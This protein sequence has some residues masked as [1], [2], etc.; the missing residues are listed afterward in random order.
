MA[1][2]PILIRILRR[3]DIPFL[4]PYR[5]YLYRYT[6][7]FLTFLFYTSYHLSRKPISIVKGELHRN[8]SE[9]S[10]YNLHFGSQASAV[11]L[12]QLPHIDNGDSVRMGNDTWCDWKPFDQE[13]YANLFGALD[14]AFL[15]SYAL[16][17]FASGYIGERMPLRYFLGFGMIICGLCTT[18]FGM[19]YFWN[20]HNLGF[21][22]VAQILNGI[23]QTTGWPGVVSAVGKW[24]GKG[25][26][27][28]IMGVWN[29]HT[30]VGNILGSV[31][32]SKFVQ[33]AWGWSFV[34]PGIII[35]SMGI[36]CLLALVEE[37]K[38]VDC[39][40]PVHEIVNTSGY[41]R[42]A[43]SEQNPD[44]EEDVM[45]NGVVDSSA[46]HKIPLNDEDEN[47]NTRVK[48][49]SKP[50]GIL[51]ALSIPGVVEFSLSLFFAKLVS[52]TFLFWLPM[53]IKASSSMNAK[54]SGLMSTFFD[55][56]GIAGGIAAGLW[57]DFTGQRASTCGIMLI[58]GAG[59]MYL[60][61]AF[62]KVSTTWSIVLLLTT[63]A[64]V[65]GPYALITTAVSADLGTHSVLRG[66][67]KAIATVT[68][69]IDGTGSIGAAIGPLLTGLIAP[70]GKGWNN[71]FYMLIASNIAS[72]LLLL[73]II[74]KEMRLC[75][76]NRRSESRRIPS[77]AA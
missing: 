70:Q 71:V 28:F 36:L 50:I 16:S 46:S 68:A 14:Y 15:F 43:T 23:F 21:F 22:I 41:E 5:E 20:I 32:A 69:I 35:G 8:C 64:F 18:L 73:R 55:V 66:N 59:M 54:D 74:I 37:P 13:N 3:F 29:S 75:L 10:S 48:E 45:E 34:V 47:L 72:L 77:L 11:L 30:S 57:S 44:A 7:L 62:G 63:G 26:R 60:Y 33:T 38:D 27:G 17:M 65:N 67:A 6:V 9:N 52:Y 40:R 39:Q 49:D 1:P 76:V 24:F 12:D 58:I 19:G 51:T 2:V 56:G 61:N 25:R 4:R 42:L 53:Y 31:I